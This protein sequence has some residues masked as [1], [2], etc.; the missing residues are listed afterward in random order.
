MEHVLRYFMQLAEEETQRSI[1]AAAAQIDT[2]LASLLD[3]EDLEAE[4][5]PESLMLATIGGAGDSK[6]RRARAHRPHP[7]SLSHAR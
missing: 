4:E 1:D 5:T 6:V 3:F 7:R 2:S